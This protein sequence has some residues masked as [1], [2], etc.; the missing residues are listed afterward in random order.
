LRFVS[1]DFDFKERNENEIQKTMQLQFNLAGNM[2]TRWR[3][4]SKGQL[5]I[6]R[7]TVTLAWY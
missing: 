6:K 5:A 3:F 2:S 1:V 7:D 4:R